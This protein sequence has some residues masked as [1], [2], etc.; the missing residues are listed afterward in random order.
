[1]ATSTPGVA[2]AR[3]GGGLMQIAVLL[4]DGAWTILRNGGVLGTAITRSVAL[5]LAHALRFQ[6]EA[7]GW[8]V[9]FVSHDPLGELKT[10]WSGE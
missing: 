4:K 5:E 6:A 1:M 2:D 8:Q 10:R 9:E 3:S 7:E